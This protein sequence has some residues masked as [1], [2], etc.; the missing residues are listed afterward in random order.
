MVVSKKLK[1]VQKI[2]ILE[3]VQN[4]N[5]SKK[6]KL[7]ISFIKKS[8]SEKVVQNPKIY[9]NLCKVKIFKIFKI[10]IFQSNSKSINFISLFKSWSKHKNLFKCVKIIYF[11]I[12]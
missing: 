9:K 4:H 6:W 7:T 8:H 12:F 5:F 1:S 2:Q 3:N 11:K 10:I